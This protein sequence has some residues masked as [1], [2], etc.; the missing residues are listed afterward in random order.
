MI[1]PRVGIA[2]DP[3]IHHDLRA[4]IG[5]RLEQHRV[6]VGVGGQSGGARLER[7]GPANL[8]PAGLMGHG[9]CGIVGHILGFEGA[10]REALPGEQSCHPGDDQ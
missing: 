10:H 1:G 7:L 5:L 8:A 4:D 9:G 3:A 2:R 6:H